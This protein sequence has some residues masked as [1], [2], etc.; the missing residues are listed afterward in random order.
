MTNESSGGLDDAVEFGLDEGEGLLEGFLVVREVVATCE[1]EE[2]KGTG[3]EGEE[4][5]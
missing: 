1:R 5:C 3:K 4:K 2:G